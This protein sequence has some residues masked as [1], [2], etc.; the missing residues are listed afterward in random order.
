MRALRVIGALLLVLYGVSYLWLS[1]D[2]AARGAG[3][4]LWAL[5]EALVIITVAG[6]MVAAWGLVKAAP[7][8]LPMSVFA[9]VAGLATLVPFLAA[10]PDVWA[11][12][13]AVDAAL[14]GLGGTALLLILLIPP[15]E[16]TL[17]RRAGTAR[18][19]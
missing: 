5:V 8:W 9:T 1:P 19:G 12:N 6:F 14:H 18:G 4:P 10:V 11:S 13:A 2:M 3:G 7:W 16:R 17:S 15:A